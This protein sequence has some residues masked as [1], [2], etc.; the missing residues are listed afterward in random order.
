MQD[1]RGVV[2]NSLPDHTSIYSDTRGQ[3]EASSSSGY[4]F[5]DAIMYENARHF[6]P[7]LPTAPPYSKEHSRTSARKKIHTWIARYES[8]QGTRSD[9]LNHAGASLDPDE[10][11]ELRS[12][13][14]SYPSDEVEI[15]DLWRGMK[16]KRSQISEL[17]AQMA[18]KRKELRAVRRRKNDADNAFMTFVRPIMVSKTSLRHTTASDLDRRMLGM[19]QLRD[20]YQWLEMSYEDLEDRLDKEEE[21]LYQIE[22]RFFS[23]L[24]TGDDAEEI[25]FPSQELERKALEAPSDIPI[26]LLGIAAEKP[27]EDLHPHFVDLTL[28]IASLQNEREELSNLV[29]TKK[30]CDAEVEVKTRVGQKIPREIL[31]FLT[32]FRTQE[33]M[34]QKE[35]A[36]DEREVHRLRQICEQKDIMGKHL[37]I[38]MAVALDP[39]LEFEDI[40]LDDQAAIIATHDSMAHK[41][42]PTLLSQ[43]DH[44]LADPMPLLPQRALRNAEELPRDDPRWPSMMHN[45]EKQCQIQ[46]LMGG[47]ERDEDKVGYIN[48]WLLQDLR[49]SP[50]NAVLLHSTFVDTQTLQIRNISRWQND[51]LRYWWHDDTAATAAHFGEIDK[52][53]Q[54]Y[55]RVGTPPPTRAA[56]EDLNAAKT[57]HSHRRAWSGGAKSH[58]TY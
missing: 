15:E 50:L 10:E 30:Q 5:D 36:S 55:S 18:Q 1:L 42:F 43:P 54:Y 2:P 41:D 24:G 9:R 7:R 25:E 58:R 6:P 22:L 33:A 45:A 40:R 34:K 49:T 53:S 19:Q 13:T 3:S 20:E 14:F 8:S 23:L 52:G 56:S 21:I 39:T 37:S 47:I 38:H 48:R 35:V 17:K 57:N 27:L 16:R 4:L 12:S 46:Q 29:E 28:A 31:E 51:V 11:D 32:D 26:D 44:L